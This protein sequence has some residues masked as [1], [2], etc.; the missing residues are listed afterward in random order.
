MIHKSQNFKEMNKVSGK[1]QLILALKVNS[2]AS[3]MN[4]WKQFTSNLKNWFKKKE[5]EAKREGKG[6]GKKEGRKYMWLQIF[7][8][9]YLI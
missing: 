6:E 1:Y 3:Q 7:I 4:D 5:R 9:S 2:S 8:T